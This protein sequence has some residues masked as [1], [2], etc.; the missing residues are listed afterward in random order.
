M[1]S[2]CVH[3]DIFKVVLGGYRSCP[4]THDLSQCHHLYDLG[5]H[6]QQP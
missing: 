5:R 4:D 3:V 1:S 2:T 6:T